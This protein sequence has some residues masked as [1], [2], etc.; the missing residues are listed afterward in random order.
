MDV[1]PK[2]NIRHGPRSGMHVSGIY[3]LIS[4][5]IPLTGYNYDSI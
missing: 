2:T 4:D 5:T 1:S 3:L